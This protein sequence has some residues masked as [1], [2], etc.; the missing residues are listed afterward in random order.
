MLRLI[1]PGRTAGASRGRGIVEGTV[2]THVELIYDKLGVHD[3]LLAVAEGRRR[4]YL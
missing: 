4:G 1:A 2:R 3:R